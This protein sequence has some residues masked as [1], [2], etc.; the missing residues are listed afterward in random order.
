MTP[1]R[2][3]P[4]CIYLVV[5]VCLPVLAQK[6][7]IDPSLLKKANAG[8][9]QAQLKLGEA[10]LSGVSDAQDYTKAASWF[11]KAA[12]QGLGQAQFDMGALYE[13]ANRVQ[14]DDTKAASR[15]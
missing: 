14:Q 5:F 2:I 1:R 10:Y 9:V 7:A 15:Y 12:D 4:L 8:D 6:A 13:T 11:Q 3:L